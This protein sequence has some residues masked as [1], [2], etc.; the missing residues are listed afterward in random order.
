[1]KEFVLWSSLVVKVFWCKANR[2][3]TPPFI[4]SQTIQIILC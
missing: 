2:K 1:M 3:K 4:S